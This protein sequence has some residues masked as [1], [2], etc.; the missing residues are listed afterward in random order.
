MQGSDFSIK[1][2]SYRLLVNGAVSSTKNTFFRVGKWSSKLDLAVNSLNKLP[3][4]NFVS[5]ISSFSEH[6]EFLC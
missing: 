4:R 3:V 1:P 6:F 5:Q 2:Q